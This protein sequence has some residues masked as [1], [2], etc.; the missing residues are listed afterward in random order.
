MGKPQVHSHLKK[1]KLAFMQCHLSIFH[2]FFFQ[3]H[4]HYYSVL[5]NFSFHPQFIPPPSIFSQFHQ[6]HQKN[7]EKEDD[8]IWT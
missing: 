4:Y 7:D 6:Q 3:R 2:F 5:H 1:I 8:K